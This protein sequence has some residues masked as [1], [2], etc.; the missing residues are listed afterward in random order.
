MCLR[1]LHICKDAKIVESVY[2]SS[3][4]QLMSCALWF[5]L[6]LL[7]CL[8]VPRRAQQSKFMKEWKKI[9]YYNDTDI[10]NAK[11]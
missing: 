4:H 7:S 2:F 5:I 8:L 9:K 10:Y 6:I 3:T 11:F 1:F